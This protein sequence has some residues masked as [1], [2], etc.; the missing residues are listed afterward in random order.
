MRKN[1]FAKGIVLAAVFAAAIAIVISAHTPPTRS[2]LKAPPKSGGEI[3]EK[4]CAKCHGKD[5]RGKTFRGKMVHAQDF[6]DPNWQSQTSNDQIA[7]SIADGKNKMPAYGNKLSK[8]E[9]RSLVEVVR[10]FK[11]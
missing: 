2:A 6:T 7:K 8:E 1:V 5:G 10:G 9:I 3:Y 4:E 11:D